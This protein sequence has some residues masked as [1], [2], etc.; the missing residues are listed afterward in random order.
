MYTNEA[1]SGAF[2]L[3]TAWLTDYNGNF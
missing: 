3:E 1:A 2:Q